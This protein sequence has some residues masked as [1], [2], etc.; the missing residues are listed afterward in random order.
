MLTNPAATTNR[1]YV[2]F[3]ND[4]GRLPDDLSDTPQLIRTIR[5]QKWKYSVYFSPDGKK[6]EY[7][8]YDLTN[9]P[10]EMSNIA[11]VKGNAKIQIKLHADLEKVIMKMRTLPLFLW[12]VSDEM[13][14]IGFMPAYHWP[15]ED[16]AWEQSRIQ[17]EINKVEQSLEIRKKIKTLRI[18]SIINS[19]SPDELWW[20]RPKK[21]EYNL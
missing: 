20:I 15:T 13:E 10:H 4:D 17:Y 14:E 1:E 12:F 16:E 3:A 19:L 2:H 5:S 11:G 7:E 8:L 21:M 18:E 9:D 6:F